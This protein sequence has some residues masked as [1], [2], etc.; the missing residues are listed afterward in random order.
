MKN[1]QVKPEERDTMPAEV[2]TEMLCDPKVRLSNTVRKTCC[3][4]RHKV[5]PSVAPIVL[6]KESGEYQYMEVK[7]RYGRYQPHLLTWAQLHK[8]HKRLVATRLSYQRKW[9]KLVAKRDAEENEDK[10]AAL[11]KLIDGV[12]HVVTSVI[13]V[14]IDLLEDEIDSRRKK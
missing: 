6:D 11:Q 2:A 1:E 13:D 14:R 10:K 5:F 12:D 4:A 3:S 9:E 8:W 7:K